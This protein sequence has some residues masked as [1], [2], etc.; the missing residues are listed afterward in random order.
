MF[1]VLKL[2]LF[3]VLLEVLFVVVFVVLQLLLTHVL[4]V[5]SP[6]GITQLGYVP[7]VPIG[8]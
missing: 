4:F 2:L 3:V 1:V 5:I 6:G 8:H 7:V